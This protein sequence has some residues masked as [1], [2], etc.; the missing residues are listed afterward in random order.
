MTLL[1][2]PI[3]TGWAKPQ[4]ICGTRTGATLDV[5]ATSRRAGRSGREMVEA[6]DGATATGTMVLIEHEPPFDGLSD[7]VLARVTYGFVASG[8]ARE[9]HDRHP[10]EP[11]WYSSC[12]PGWNLEVPGRLSVLVEWDGGTFVAAS[13][14]KLRGTSD[15]E[16]LLVPARR[17]MWLPNPF[18]AVGSGGVLDGPF[19][20]VS[21]LQPLAHARLT[22]C[23]A[24]GICAHWRGG[25]TVAVEPA[26]R[27]E[28]VECL[29]LYVPSSGFVPFDPSW[30]WPTGRLEISL[31]ASR[32][33]R[34]PG[35]EVASDTVVHC[36]FENPSEVAEREAPLS[37]TDLPRPEPAS[38]G[39]SCDRA[40]I[41]WTTPLV[42]SGLGFSWHPVEVDVQVSQD[43]VVLHRG[44]V[45]P[46]YLW[47]E[48][49][50]PGCGWHS[51]GDWESPG[52]F[53]PV[54][55]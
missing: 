51:T 48:R 52:T 15:G 13:E 32:V 11:Y 39:L 34:A 29:L 28:P 2:L 43:G 30:S 7:E 37:L 50:G 16:V 4:N 18:F 21:G 49:N 19:V 26:T 53:T 9:V 17:H 45:R 41:L 22:A 12:T 5:E 25:G 8:P 38:V 10:Y 6:V 35:Q 47:S 1:W 36:V 24:D 33:W 27:P 40:V 46:N 44:T 31:S 55:P 54:P 20:D 42:V 14:G 3:A 23:S